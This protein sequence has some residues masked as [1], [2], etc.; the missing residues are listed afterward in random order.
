MKTINQ[1]KP[2]NSEPSIFS[3]FVMKPSSTARTVDM[4]VPN[5]IVLGLH[6]TFTEPVFPY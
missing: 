2:P 6:V 1:W 5:Y 3:G 4:D